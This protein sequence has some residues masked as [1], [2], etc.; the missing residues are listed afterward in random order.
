MRFARGRRL[1]GLPGLVRA[2]IAVTAVA[3]G[4]GLAVLIGL[5]SADVTSSSYTIGTPTPPVTS[6]VASPS[7]VGVDTSTTFEV[8]FTAGT[9]LSG[10]AGD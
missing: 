2:A 10:A 8:S 7:T 9:G 5:A 3:L 1:R 6:V 4:A